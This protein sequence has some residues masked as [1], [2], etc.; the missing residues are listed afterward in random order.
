M[1]HDNMKQNDR[2]ELDD[3]L[4]RLMLLHP[5][6][7][8]DMKQRLIELFHDNLVIILDTHNTHSM[9][10][11]FSADDEQYGLKAEFGQ[12]Q[13][14][15]DEAHW[16]ELAPDE[17][18]SH[19]IVSHVA[20]EYAFVLLRWLQNAQTIEQLA[21]ANEGRKDNPTIEL[22]IQALEQDQKLFDSASR[23]KLLSG[24]DT[25]YFYD[26]YKAYNAKAIDFPYLQRLIESDVVRVNGRELAGPNRYVNAIQKNDTL[27]E[28]L[29]PHVAGLIHG[30]SHMDNLLVESNT[31]YFIDP[32]GVDHLPLEYDTGRVLW[33]L[34]GWNAIVNGEFNLI[35][36]HD[37]YQLSVAKRQQ[38]EAG[39]PKIKQYFTQQEYHRALYSAA[40]QYVTRVSHAEVEREAT[41]LYLQGIMLF[42]DLFEELNVILD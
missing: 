23:I 28:Y 36:D 26:K 8:G 9:I 6:S 24:H 1:G 7:R 42:G 30:D 5:T 20:D 31:V 17:L 4:G 39:M 35:S 32:K 3:V 29:S 25:G 38:Y 12:A 19:H 14:T 34:T 2:S 33:S 15:R 22:V 11:V 21:I 18:K 41:A 13:V 37:G 27:R 40:I 16:Y 10:F